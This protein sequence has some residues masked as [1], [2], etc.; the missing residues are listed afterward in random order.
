MHSNAANIQ[1]VDFLAILWKQYERI[2]LILT[3]ENALHENEIASCE[4]ITQLIAVE[5]VSLSMY[6][7]WN[8]LQYIN[9]MHKGSC[10]IYTEESGSEE[11][12]NSTHPIV[13]ESRN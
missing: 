3:V 2:K 5:Y 4:R 6:L 7:S 9:A 8:D 12:S 10:Y 13:D 11:Y 1:S